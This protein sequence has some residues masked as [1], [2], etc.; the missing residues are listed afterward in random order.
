MTDTPKTKDAPVQV[1]RPGVADSSAA[2]VATGSA[3][4][5][6]TPPARPQPRPEKAQTTKD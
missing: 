5:G 1:I 6:W 3:P 4:P 2:A